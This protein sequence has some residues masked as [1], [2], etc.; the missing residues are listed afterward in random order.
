MNLMAKWT[1]SETMKLTPHTLLP[2]LD[3]GLPGGQVAK[4]LGCGP[5]L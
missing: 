2:L 1:T 5:R 3:Y 4:A